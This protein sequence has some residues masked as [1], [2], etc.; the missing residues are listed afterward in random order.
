M[1]V[2]NNLQY[3]YNSETPECDIF[4]FII[5]LRNFLNITQNTFQKMDLFI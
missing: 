5:Y 1:Q 4:M 3:R 2:L